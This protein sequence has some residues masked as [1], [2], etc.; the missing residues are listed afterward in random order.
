MKTAVVS[1]TVLLAAALFAAALYTEYR[2]RHIQAEFEPSGQ[3]HDVAGVRLHVVDMVPDG[4]RTGD[5]TLVFLHGASGNLLDQKLAF[6]D[7][8]GDRYRLVFVDRPGHGFSDRGGEK[9]HSPRLQAGLVAELLR[10][11]GADHVVAVG[12]S[13]GGS[14]AVELGLNHFDIVKGIVFVAP[15]THPWEGGVT[16]YYEVAAAPF[17]GKLFTRTLTLP[18]GELLAPRTIDS[19]FA[20]DKAPPDYLEKIA[21]PLLFRP[22]T[23]RANAR[24]VT[25]LHAHVSEAARQYPSIPVPAI[26]LT[27]DRD[28]IV[29]AHIHSAGLA[30]DLPHAELREL[31]GAG[32]MPHH[33]RTAEVVAAIEDVVERSRTPER[34]ELVQASE[35][36]A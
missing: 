34:K 17:I 12:H 6:S 9:A 8:L 26:V 2:R 35:P 18:V 23:F 7:A 22:E 29:Y 31:P 13:W 36:A 14:V 3:F 19:V 33:S 16:W 15:A 4:W 32:H 21:L 28:G 27:G 5:P 20:P 30:R 1:F 25:R 11:L 10:K 24:D